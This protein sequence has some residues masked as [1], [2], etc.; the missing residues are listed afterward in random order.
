MTTVRKQNEN[1]LLSV[2][3]LKVRFGGAGGLQ[4]VDGVSYAVE[5]S[6]RVALV[7]ES[8][9]G[10]SVSSL[11]ILKLLA[12]PPAQVNAQTMAF[13]G[14]D[15]LPLKENQMG[16]VRGTGMGMIFQDPATARNPVYTIGEQVAEGPRYHFGLNKKDARAAAQD[17]LQK[18]GIKDA[19][20]RYDSYPHELSGGM[21][22]RVM[23]AG[24]LILK[25]RLLFADEPTTA[26]DVTIQK[27]IL[28]LLLELQQETAMSVLLITHDLGVVRQFAQRVL[29]MYAG[30]IVEEAPTAAL[31]EQQHHP[32]TQGLFRCLPRLNQRVNR[33][34]AIE[35]VPPDLRQNIPGCRFAPRCPHV[36]DQCRQSAPPLVQQGNRHVRCWLEAPPAVSA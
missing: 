22:Q 20:G 18:V 30:Q 23:I 17:M 33:L 19:A 6:E 12:T 36:T 9:S 35:G 13:E 32:Y 7:G 8:G 5:A 3:N 2:Q 16:Q 25:P 14:K 31:F 29:V 21:R 28:E 34:F 1:T 26:L 27:Q 11:A 4:A 24:A 10:K 15:L